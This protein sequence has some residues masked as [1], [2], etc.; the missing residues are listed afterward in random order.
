[1]MKQDGLVEEV[2]NE[3]K[4]TQQRKIQDIEEKD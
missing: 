3:L 4:Q 2:K 1:M